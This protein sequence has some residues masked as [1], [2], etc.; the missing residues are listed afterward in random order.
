MWLAPLLLTLSASA[1]PPS[2]ARGPGVVRWTLVGARPT[3]ARSLPASYQ[4]YAGITLTLE[5]RRQGFNYRFDV[6]PG[7]D[8][9]AI[10]MRYEGAAGVVAEGASLR[11]HAGGRTLCE[12]GLRCF[13]D[14]PVREVA[15]WY[16]VG[17]ASDGA[18]EVAIRVG[19]YDRR[20]ALVIDP[21]IAWS[22]YLG[23]EGID[24]GWGIAVDGSGNAYVAGT[25]YSVDFPS[26][27]GFDTS[28]NGQE[29]AFV[30]KVDAS[31]SSLAWGSYLGGAGYDEAF[32]IAVDGSGNAYV[33]GRTESSDFPAAGGFDTELDGLRDVFVTK[34]DSS[35][36]SLAWSSY[37]GGSDF[38][39]G[40]GIAVDGSGN[41]YVTGYA[42]SS[43]FPSA[44]GFDTTYDGTFD[45]FVTKVD[46]SGSSM[47]WSSF[48]GGSNDDYGLGIAVDGLDN[49]YVTGYTL[50]SDFPAVGGFGTSPGLGEDAFV[51]KVDAAGSSLAWSSYL[52]ASNNDRGYGIAVDGSGNAYVVGRTYSSDF[53]SAGGFDST[54]GG[55]LDAF[56]AKVDAAGSS[57]AWS[58]Y[59]G[60]SDADTAFAIAVDGSGN[61]YVTG[62]T[63]SSDFPSAGGFDTTYHAGSDAFVT[64]VAAPG[65]S[66]AW[67]SYLGGNGDDHGRGIAVD[68]AGN[69]TVGGDTYSFDFPA[70][71]GF[72]TVQGSQD[73]FVTRIGAA[74]CGDGSCGPAETC[75]NCPADC[76]ACSEPTPDASGADANTDG[77]TEAD[78]PTETDG[79]NGGGKSSGGC[80]SI[81]AAP[82]GPASGMV[83]M[84][85][86]AIAILARRRC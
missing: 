23:G 69:V 78:G 4:A 68:D 7:G 61:A 3:A 75:A 16:D 28:Q 39:E 10:R 66:L 82:S 42:H 40:D 19:A 13:Q 62:T 38:E 8:P 9:S 81:G 24:Q 20:G 76:G 54:R 1:R 47:V 53:P 72:D 2:A 43:D 70:T 73:A 49:V 86:A 59:L 80:C 21:T 79:G 5:P 14:D 25:E 44:G 36:S 11:I 51:A 83:W 41:V 18:A 27:G 56:V 33:T 50:S 71:G 85:A 57:L 26:A 46:A 64:E 77:A 29:D 52:G 15:C 34:V 60:G 58:S 37:L 17:R 22:S 63:T 32:A 65:S 30:A 74:T 67:S 35:G 84:V 31:G 6:A 45:A 55:P 12:R 48:L